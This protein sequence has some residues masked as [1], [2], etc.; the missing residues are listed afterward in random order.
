[1]IEED[2]SKA[3]IEALKEERDA[4][5]G[6]ELSLVHELTA[7]RKKLAKLTGE[8]ILPIRRLP[9]T[10]DTSKGGGSSRG[11]SKGKVTGKDDGKSE[12]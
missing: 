1:M 2:K 5:L 3:T 6:R 7:V 10:R 9:S 8:N 4:A 12:H 11:K